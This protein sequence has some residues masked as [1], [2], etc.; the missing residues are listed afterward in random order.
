[1]P[2]S[3][4]SSCSTNSFNFDN[5]ASSL[6]NQPRLGLGSSDSEN[7]ALRRNL[8]EMGLLRKKQKNL[9]IEQQYT[10]KLIDLSSKSIQV[11]KKMSGKLVYAV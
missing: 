7:I 5:N 6:I 3:R 4:S 9:T 2:D 8:R 1:M 11:S 10:E